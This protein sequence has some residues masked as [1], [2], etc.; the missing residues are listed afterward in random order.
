MARV[1]TG[2]AT[3]GISGNDIVVEAEKFRGDPYVWGASG[4]SSFDC[5]GLVQYT[6]QRLGVRNVPRTSEAQWAWVDKIPA[7]QAEPGDLVFFTGADGVS[8]GHVGILTTAGT[9]QHGPQM[10]D[11]PH[12]GTVV[13]IQGFDPAAG[14]SGKVVGYGRVPG[15]AAG[16]AAPGPKAASPL[17]WPGE[18]TGFFGD[19]DRALGAL[20]QI[21]L[22]FFQPSTYIRLALGAFAVIFLVAGLIFL[23]KA[24]V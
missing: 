22:A 3:G 5:S 9:A 12:T 15:S 20:S 19:A 4:P 13:Q 18:V 17:S 8:P 11:A 23:V 24:A 1:P 6:L 14:G 2:S 10:I 21:T 16:V 7:S